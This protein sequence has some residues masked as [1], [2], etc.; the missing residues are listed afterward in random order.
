MEP[1]WE[2]ALTE[3]L[4]FELRR[5][6]LRDA[7]GSD[8]GECLLRI[9][10]R[11]FL[12]K[13][14]R[15]F[16]TSVNAHWSRPGIPFETKRAAFRRV[17]RDNFLLTLSARWQ[18]ETAPPTERAVAGC[19]QDLTR[20]DRWDRYS[21]I[22]RR[23]IRKSEKADVRLVRTFAPETFYNLTLAH[24]E[25]QGLAPPP[26]TMPQFV[27]FAEILHGEG[28]LAMFSTRSPKASITASH[29]CLLKKPCAYD[30]LSVRHP[31]HLDAPDNYY[32]LDAIF[33]SMAREGYTVFDHCGANLPQVWKFKER[34]APETY[35]LEE[36]RLRFPG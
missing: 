29:L 30:I 24:N 3:G 5:F 19:R 32:L 14:A 34:F 12:K 27:R 36:C 23:C 11:W 10:R 4:G 1:L 18:P 17:L 16:A 21:E 33:G 22:V 9:G 20:A 7:E 26:F 31:D 6:S 28:C 25:R 8:M 35:C 13:G 15:P 2:R